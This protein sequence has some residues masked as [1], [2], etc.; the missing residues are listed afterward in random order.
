[1]TGERAPLPPPGA[2]ARRAMP[3][4]LRIE[5]LLVLALFAGLFKA[6]AIDLPRL[7][8]LPL[9]FWPDPNDVYADGYSTAWWAFNGGMYDTWKTVY[10]PASFVLTKLLGQTRCYDADVVFVRDCD[11]SLWLW[12]LGFYVLNGW[13]AWRTYRARDG[14]SAVPRTIGLMLGLPMLYAFE[15]LNLLVFAYTGLIAFFGTG[16]RS[17][18]T[19]WLGLAV[20]INLKIYLIVVLLGQLFK[21]R[22]RA[23][24][25]TL[26]LTVAVYLVTYAIVGSGTPMQV[27]RNIVIFSGDPQRASNWAYVF[28]ASSYQSMTEF[29]LS[30]F[31][32]MPI[33]GSWRL[34]FWGSFLRALILAVQAVTLATFAAI[35][36]R[37]QIVPRARVAAMCYLLVLI[38]NET[39]GY[40]TAGAVF[41]VFFERWQ[42]A[43]RIASLVAAWL[44]CLAFDYRLVPIGAS[45]QNGYFGGRPVWNDM[46]LSVGPF[47]RPGLIMLMDLGLVVASWGD[48]VRHWRGRRWPQT[49]SSTVLPESPYDP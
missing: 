42:G 40:T 44:L 18:R 10:P 30:E 37:P 2:R 19:R 7:G 38:S 8:Y 27:Y 28:Y 34:E 15:H 33:V 36:G 47:V 39:G 5:W 16:I 23:V 9:P 21:R 29:F 32:L 48:L 31:R 45:V 3:F 46:W 43:G 11:W 41:L 4:G 35:W 20:A 49:P 1:M 12:T 14:R 22:W 25:G 24:E 6:V 17:A 26:I 13:L